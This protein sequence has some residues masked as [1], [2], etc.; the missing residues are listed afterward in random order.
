MRDFEISTDSNCDL[1]ADEIKN[2]G[3]F[4]GHLSYTITTKD[5][6]LTEYLDNYTNCQQYVDFF[7]LLRNGCIAKT[8]ILYL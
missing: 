5:G 3:I 7:N 1:Y 4:V 2:L 8:S 6:Q